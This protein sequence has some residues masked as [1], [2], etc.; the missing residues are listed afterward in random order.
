MG[1]FF[2]VVTLGSAKS[3]NVWELLQQ[4]SLQ[5]RCPSCYQLNND[6]KVLKG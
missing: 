3:P 6:V 4:D 1:Q 5:A 2:S